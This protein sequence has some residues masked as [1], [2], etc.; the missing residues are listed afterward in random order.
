[1]GSKEHLDFCVMDQRN[2]EIKTYWLQFIQNN[3]RFIGIGSESPRTTMWMH[4]ERGLIQIF[5][6]EKID[7][8]QRMQLQRYY[9]P[10]HL[11]PW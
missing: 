3:Y 10:T 6:N 1:M 8:F 7:K 2:G 5:V 11:T 9:T 4:G